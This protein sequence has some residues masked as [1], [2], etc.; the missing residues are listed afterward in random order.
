ME[1]I[2]PY[3]LDTNIVSL[4]IRGNAAVARH[5]TATP[6]ASL[7]IS[8]IT[9]AE[10]HF[11]LAK[12]PDAQ[13]LHTAVKQ[14]LARVDVLPWDSRVAETYGQLRTRLESVGRPLGALDTMIAAHALYTGAVLVTND[15]A[16]H[17][18]NGLKIEDW[19]KI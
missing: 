5:V 10:L 18:V 19:S 12:R 15:Q 7:G 4:L 16:F 1:G 8:A 2:S 11:G 14:F 9:C 17:Q 6:M 13:L 3:L